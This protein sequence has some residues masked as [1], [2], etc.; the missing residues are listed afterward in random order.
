MSFVTA[1]A[2]GRVFSQEGLE[3]HRAVGNFGLGRLGGFRDLQEVSTQSEFVGTLAVG[4]K[5]VVADTLESAGQN[6]EEKSPNKLVGVEGHCFIGAPGFVVLVG[7]GYLSILHAGEPMVGDGDAVGVAGQV[8]EHGVGARKG[9]F[10]KND[11]F[12][13]ATTLQESLKGKLLG[14]LCDGAMELQSTVTKRFF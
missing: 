5:S 10:G 9:R 13:P 14:E 11:P 12:E 1:G 2:A 6:V 7:E 3:K 4:E 8:I